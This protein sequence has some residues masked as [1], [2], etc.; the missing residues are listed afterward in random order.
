MADSQFSLP[1]EAAHDLL[2]VRAL[3]D[4][5]GKTVQT[6]ADFKSFRHEVSESI[7]EFS[8][9]VSPTLKS[10]K[11]NYF[12]KVNK[13]CYKAQ[14]ISDDFTN[15]PQINLCKQTVHHEIFGGLYK[16]IYAHRASDKMRLDN[17]LTDAGQ[18]LNGAISCLNNFKQDTLKSND[19]LRAIVKKDY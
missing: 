8:N 11:Q 1:K 19:T 17:C 16:T 6:T 5:K 3:K 14:H 18:D 10:L 15:E 9:S 7:F 13:D 12:D 2:L 4:T